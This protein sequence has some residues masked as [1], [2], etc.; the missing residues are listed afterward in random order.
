[1]QQRR[2]AEIRAGL[3]TETRDETGDAVLFQPLQLGTRSYFY[4][5]LN[6]HGLRGCGDPHRRRMT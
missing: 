2:G 1:L 5:R 3:N 4:G 6:E